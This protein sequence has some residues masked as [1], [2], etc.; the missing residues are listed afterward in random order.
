MAACACAKR[1]PEQV[2]A[3][4][5]RRMVAGH[6]KA[7]TNWVGFQVAMQLQGRNG[8]SCIDRSLLEVWILL[9][10]SL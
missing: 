6:I 8:S 9:G 1:K 2:G 5:R 7:G 10:S 3:A 4:C